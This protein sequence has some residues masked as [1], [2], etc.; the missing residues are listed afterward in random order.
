VVLLLEAPSPI[1]WLVLM[2]SPLRALTCAPLVERSMGLA[3]VTLSRNPFVVV[4]ISL[5]VLPGA[6]RNVPSLIVPPRRFTL[7]MASVRVK[8]PVAVPV[9]FTVPPVRE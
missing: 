4:A 1:G 3:I 7:P 6:T 9:R 5:A 8:S 2:V